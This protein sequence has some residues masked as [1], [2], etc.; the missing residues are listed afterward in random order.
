MGKKK[1]MRSKPKPEN[2][3]VSKEG[4]RRRGVPGAKAEIPLQHVE[5]TMLELQPVED[6]TVKQVPISRRNCRASERSAYRLTTNSYS[7]SPCATQSRSQ[8]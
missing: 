7:P 1:R 3:K 6:P 2:T 5:R 8:G 4:E